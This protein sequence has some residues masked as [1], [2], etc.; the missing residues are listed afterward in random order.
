MACDPHGPA[1]VAPAWVRRDATFDGV[2][3]QLDEYF[4]GQRTRFEIA[5]DLAGTPFQ[6]AVWQAL[7]A[8]P[9]GITISYG[10][11]AQRVGNAKAVRAVGLAN[12]RN[13]VAIVVPCHRVIGASG[14]LTGYGGGLDNKHRLLALEM[15]REPLG[16][17]LPAPVSPWDRAP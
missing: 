7:C 10:A 11:L 6:R 5:L 1:V 17:L 12:G 15:A 2:R 3:R 14:A 13:P 9:Y 4:A 16:H 8:I